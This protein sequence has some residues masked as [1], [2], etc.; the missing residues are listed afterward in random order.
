MRSLRSRSRLTLALLVALLAAAGLGLDAGTAQGY[1]ENLPLVGS[2]G[3]NAFTRDCPASHVLTGIRWRRG[4]VLDGVGI[5]CRPVRSDGTLGT[6]INSGTMA[7][8]NGGTAGSASCPGSTV[9]VSQAG[10]SQAG[11]GIGILVL[12][13]FRWFPASRSWGGSS[14]DHISVKT[15]GV[16]PAI[17]TSTCTLGTQPARGIRGRHGMVVDSF[18]LRCATP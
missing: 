10:A 4:L 18:G 5:K 2:L 13:C 3:G 8:G 15:G 11:V 12:G 9:I 16:V 17:V 6:E 14:L 1:V 7:G